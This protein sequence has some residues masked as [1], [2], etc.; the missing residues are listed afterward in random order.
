L[1]DLIGDDDDDDA[2]ADDGWIWTRRLGYINVC[3]GVCVGVHIS[4]YQGLSPSAMD[5]GPQRE[6]LPVYCGR[7][8]VRGPA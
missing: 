3:V 1:I 6:S 2:D 7:M 8:N 4:R 5:L